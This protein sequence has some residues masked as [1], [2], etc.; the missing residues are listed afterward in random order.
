MVLHLRWRWECYQEQ[1]ERKGG[2]QREEEMA[3]VAQYLWSKLQELRVILLDLTQSL[4]SSI[5]LSSRFDEWLLQEPP[6]EEDERALLS[7]LGGQWRE[8]KEAWWVVDHHRI[9][10]LGVIFT[11]FPSEALSG[12][13]EILDYLMCDIEYN[14]ENN[15]VFLQNPIFNKCLKPIA[16]ALDAVAGTFD[17][18]AEEESPPST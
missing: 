8:V 18:Y 13:A 2:V 4:S 5:R 1:L 14:D 17:R 3:K 16:H 6:A 15:E 7:L 10:K 11:L 9:G 12:Q